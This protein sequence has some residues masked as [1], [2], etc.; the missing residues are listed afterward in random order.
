MRLGRER[1]RGDGGAHGSS[2]DDGL[3]MG[4][5]GFWLP[6]LAK[7]VAKVTGTSDF[8]LVQ[9]NGMSA[10]LFLLVFKSSIFGSSHIARLRCNIENHHCLARFDHDIKADLSY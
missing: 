5:I 2:F 7:V 1:W 4:L 9:N 3:L 8:N 10:T 6:V